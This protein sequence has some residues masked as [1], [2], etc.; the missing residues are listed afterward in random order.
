[1]C[2][3]EG[4]FSLRRQ[5][6]TLSDLSEIPN[7]IEH[8]DLVRALTNKQRDCISDNALKKWAFYSTAYR[9]PPK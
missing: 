7:F 3:S 6:A 1:M 5:R 8:F 2:S 9:E 4:R